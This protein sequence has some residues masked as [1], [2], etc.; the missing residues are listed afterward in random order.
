MKWLIMMLLLIARPVGAS[1]GLDV[2][3]W[4]S[5]PGVKLVAVEFYASWCGPCKKAVPQW[6]ALHEQYRDQGLR[7]IVVSVQDPDG[8]CVNPGW[9]PDDVVCDTEGRLA[10]AW[11]VSSKLPAAYLWSWRGTLLVRKGHV[12]QVQRAVKEELSRLPRVALDHGMD[13]GLRDLLRADL[14]RTGKV[15]VVAGAD[16]E[17]A[18]KALRR[19]S[20]ELEFSS[21]SSCALGQRL[22]ANTLLKASLVTTGKA[23]RLVV[24]LMSAETGCLNA[25]AGVFWNKD[26]PEISVAEAIAELINNL[27]VSVE[28][29]GR[30]VTARVK[31]RTIGEQAETWNITGTDGV[32]VAFETEP[33]GAVVMLDGALLCQ[34]TPCSKLVAPGSHQLG[35]QLESYLPVRESLRLD[36]DTRN[37]KRELTPDFGWLEVASKPSGLAVFVDKKPW[38]TTPLMKRQISS[39]PHQVLVTDSHYYDK[40]K[41]IVVRRGE[42]EKIEVHL[43]P[44]EGGLKILA[45]DTGGNDVGARVLLDGRDIGATPFAGK[46]IIG[47]H[48]VRV[49]FGDSSWERTVSVMEQQVQEL[50]AVLDQSRPTPSRDR[51]H[52]P[53]DSDISNLSGTIETAFAPYTPNAAA[54]RT[55][56]PS[57]YTWDLTPLFPG[58][59]QW[60][61]AFTAL[62]IRVP[63]L[64]A[65]RGTL[66]GGAA[67]VKACLELGTDLS[68]QAD[69]LGQYAFQL[70]STDRRDPKAQE[71]YE[72]SEYISAKV[73]SALSFIEPELLALDDAALRTLQAAPSL[74]DYDHFPKD[75]A[76]RKAHVLDKSGEAVLSL[77]RALAGTPYTIL[78]SLQAETPFP[79]IQDE[80]GA[81]VQL[82]FANFPKYRSHPD[83]KVRRA[84]A[85]AFFDTLGAF[86]KSYAASLAA[87]VKADVYIAQ[88]QGYASALAASLDS[89]AVTR[90]LYDTLLEVTHKNLPRTLHRYI[91]LK[92]KLLG[93]DE[94]HYSDMYTPLFSDVKDDIAYDEAVQLTLAAMAPMGGEYTGILAKGLDP[95]ARWSDVYPNEGKKSGAYCTGHWGLHPFVFLNYMDTLDDVFTTAHEFGHAMH[96]WYSQ[97][98]QPY[99]KSDSPILLAEI[100]STFQEAMLMD[101]LIKTSKEK[102][103]TMALLVKQL[104]NIRLTVIRQVMFAEFEMLIHAEVE[105]GGALTASRLS[106]IYA[107]LVKRYFGPDFTF[108]EHDQYEWAYIPH[109]YYNFY[110]YKYATGLMAAFAFSNKILGGDEETRDRFIEFLKAGGKDYPLALLKE[111]GVDITDPET[112]EETY[113]LFA[114]TLR[115]L[116]MLLD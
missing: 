21:Q 14:A 91:K 40:G 95:A 49:T 31:E 107:D 108:D 23:K 32:I 85:K 78:N 62:E 2:K 65:C 97:K 69:R 87:K 19:K 105:K 60:M 20:H 37:V 1:E 52:A 90:E 39:G 116:E 68:L 82:G 114:K 73:S 61:A 4:L 98:T 84:A 93:L 89:D 110:V 56:V 6:R 9:N 44:R 70:W 11:G 27:R 59:A 26:R 113:E 88:A 3:D 5:R 25:S 71:L 75:L 22:A 96:F 12:E 10:E 29:P 30:A 81:D 64:E 104:E 115:K 67:K 76:R 58:N 74:A 102:R 106:E 33:V 43:L 109:F 101:H 53:M 45:R 94:I 41:D 92:K 13:A 63:D 8:S 38:G 100:P 55:E 86:S 51:A 80:S 112:M 50:E 57:M 34:S 77:T 83:R 36:G 47:N 54:D 16:E 17:A 48:K 35:F 111:A 99:P 79:K 42:Q 24:Q 15:E 72:K 28:L 18:L 7:L 46:V 66:G 103:K